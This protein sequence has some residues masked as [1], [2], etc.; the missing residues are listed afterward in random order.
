MA[1]MLDVFAFRVAQA[2]HPADATFIRRWLFLVAHREDHRRNI[3]KW[4]QKVEN[5][6]TLKV[7]GIFFYLSAIFAL[8]VVMCACFNE[9][10]AFSLL[11]FL[12]S[13]FADMVLSCLAAASFAHAALSAATLL[14]IADRILSATTLL[15]IECAEFPASVRI[16]WSRFVDMVLSCLAVV[17][18]SPVGLSDLRSGPRPCWPRFSDAISRIRPNFSGFVDT[19]LSRLAAAT[20]ARVT[21]SDL[22][23]GP[24]PCWPRVS[25]CPIL[26]LSCLAAASFAHAALSAATL[27]AIADRILSATTL[28]VIECAEFPASVRISWSRFVDM[29]L[30][31]LAVVTFS[32][33]GLSDLRSGPRPCWPRFSDAISRIRPNF[34]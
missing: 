1:A 21:L 23:S 29:V 20:F 10:A 28:L 24:R 8:C 4:W 16:S 30:S 18:F 7:S 2:W 27:L 34:S 17:T 26:V 19:V 22:R 5:A 31:C 13:I 25:D 15:V 9:A 32:P 33:V 14:A 3:S 6:A 12:C 11:H